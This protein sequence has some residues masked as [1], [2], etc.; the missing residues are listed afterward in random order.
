MRRRT[1]E[2]ITAERLKSPGTRSLRSEGS[3]SQCRLPYKLNK[4]EIQV[5]FLHTNP[6]SF[7]SVHFIHTI[8]G[9]IVVRLLNTDIH[10]RPTKVFKEIDALSKLED[11]SCHKYLD[12]K[13]SE[14]GNSTEEIS[15]FGFKSKVKVEVPSMERRSRHGQKI[16]RMDDAESP[17]DSDGPNFNKITLKDLRSMCK[18]KKQ[19]IQKSADSQQ[20]DIKGFSQDHGLSV[21]IKEE[22]EME[23]TLS[24]L[25]LKLSNSKPKR[26]DKT[27]GSACPLSEAGL[28]KV[29]AKLETVGELSVLSRIKS[30]VVDMEF[31][32]PENASAVVGNCS[33]SSCSSASG[34]E[35]C[36]VV[37]GGGTGSQ[38]SLS[39]EGVN[40]S[41]D[42][43][44][45]LT[46]VSGSS[47]SGT[48]T[49]SALLAKC[50]LQFP[51]SKAS[52]NYIEPKQLET[53]CEDAEICHGTGVMSSLETIHSCSL[54]MR[55]ELTIDDESFCSL[56]GESHCADSDENVAVDH[57]SNSQSVHAF[58][59]NKVLETQKNVQPTTASDHG[60][61]SVDDSIRL[62]TTSQNFCSCLPSNNVSDF[63]M[64][65]D[66]GSVAKIFSEAVEAR[67]A[68]THSLS[69][70]SSNAVSDQDCSIKPELETQKNVQPT[71]ASDHGDHSVDDSIRLHTISQSFHSCLPSNNVSDFLTEEDVGSV[72]K[73]FSEVVEARDALT[74]SL[75]TGSSDPVS[76]KDC[77]IKLEQISENCGSASVSSHTL[78]VVEPRTKSDKDNTSF[79]YGNN[80]INSIIGLQITPQN[81]TSCFN[82]PDIGE[83]K[84]NTTA[85]RDT[86][87]EACK[88]F[89]GLKLKISP[90]RL[91]STRKAISPL[92]R[93]K[94]LQAVD[95]EELQTSIQ[96][97]KG[98]KRLRFENG[99]KN[100]AFSDRP[101]LEDA[102]G[103]VLHR[104]RSKKSRIN[105]KNGS[106]P[107]LIKGILKT[108]NNECSSSQKNAQK[109]VMFSQMQMRHFESV[110]ANL[111]NCLK[112]M[113]D[114][115]EET[116]HSE[117]F[118][119]SP[120]KY[121]AEMRREAA[122][123]ADELEATTKRW[124]AMMSRDCNRFCKIMN[125]SDERV[126]SPA[127]KERKKIS[128]ADE[129]GFNLCHVK[130]F[131]KIS[132]LVSEKNFH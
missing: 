38:Q 86:V 15:G 110:A 33:V 27:L 57:V 49:S 66:V 61:H 35:L 29:S 73:I 132:Q 81:F 7:S 92:S 102:D 9:M 85:T 18:R 103:M 26:R 5:F 31:D 122:D 67:D 37:D 119:S 125:L 74:H 52:N 32:V 16:F 63:L 90:T 54:S 98:K 75:S 23:E 71:T 96:N 127:P 80:S 50:P 123:N 124:L 45:P 99:M 131:T 65:E 17:N 55:S 11:K 47:D 105:C 43:L 88:A 59:D 53:V 24:S 84:L 34:N 79:D 28:K 91:L 68:L 83:D 22:P 46:E 41:G 39:I 8:K 21:K 115:V 113:K 12:S 64:E 76:V 10:G 107:L 51:L 94:L 30:E 82:S 93:E 101:Y 114:I 126:T 62:H 40:F 100:E 1:T 58:N 121:T 6:M 111:L 42:A 25:K 87:A 108:Q 72:A 129:A 128:F 44:I 14:V 56:S 104:E 120:T 60:D 19:K 112:S 106:P 116:L 48:T 77:T 36:K 78:S 97:S 95:A 117:S 69:T 109:A 89:D 20:S 4:L 130:T 3:F 13:V 70:R 2:L 118:S